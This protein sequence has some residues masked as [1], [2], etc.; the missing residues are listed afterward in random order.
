MQTQ[1][2][3]ANCLK[4]NESTFN[5]YYYN[6]NVIDFEKKISTNYINKNEINDNDFTTNSDCNLYKNPHCELYCFD[7][8]ESKNSKDIDRKELHRNNS[9]KLLKY[10]KQQI[11]SN[12]TT[13]KYLMKKCSS[14]KNFLGK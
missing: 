6:N 9:F 13:Y 8:K 4:E 7:N 12:E 1:L 3:Y 10:Y 14:S 5:D 2:K 11:Y